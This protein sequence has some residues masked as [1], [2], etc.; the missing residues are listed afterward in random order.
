MVLVNGAEGIGSGW[1]TNIPCYNPED[2]VKNILR[3][4]DG[5]EPLEMTPWYRGFRGDISVINPE[6]TT[7][8]KSFLCKGTYEILEDNE[9]KITELPV[10]TWI[11]SY[12]EFLENTMDLSEGSQKKFFESYESNS[13][14]V[15]VSYKLSFS[16]E[17]YALLISGDP[18]E[19]LKLTN[20]LST[21]SL[22]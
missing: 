13:T 19:K 12:K 3:M 14:D 2:I 22:I 5:Q 16:D 10:K 11:S 1:S 8:N 7:L 17:Q 21:S 9:L 4:L 6:N 20:K 18:L 15:R